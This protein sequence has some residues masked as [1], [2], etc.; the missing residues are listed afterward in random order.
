M[1][2][3]LVSSNPLSEQKFDY[4]QLNL[5]NQIQVEFESKYN[6]FLS[7]K[8]VWRCMQNHNHFVLA[9]MQNLPL[10]TCRAL[11]EMENILLVAFSNNSKICFFLIQ[12]TMLGSTL[13]FSNDRKCQHRDPDHHPVQKKICC[14]TSMWDPLR[15]QARLVFRL[16]LSKV[17]ANE[18]RCY[19]CNV[20]SHWLLLS[21]R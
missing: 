20:F 8:W 19:M 16:W 2:L 18:T 5:Q 14:Q 12:F 15:R 13:F 10:I 11:D 6:K 9:A 4:C 7:Q 21:H 3:C 1:V 17:C